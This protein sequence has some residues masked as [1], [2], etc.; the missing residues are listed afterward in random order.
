MR[1]G[2]SFRLRW[3]RIGLESG[4]GRL[5][6]LLAALGDNWSESDLLLKG[7]RVD[8]R[9]AGPAFRARIALT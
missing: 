1:S 4:F 3:C 7:N 8:L 6:A 9:E 2:I 5:A